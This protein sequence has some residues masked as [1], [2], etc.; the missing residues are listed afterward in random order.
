[1]ALH[2]SVTGGI[3]PSGKVFTCVNG[4]LIAVIISSL[5]SG[6]IDEDT[7]CIP[8]AAFYPQVHE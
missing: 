8:M 7:G 2:L 5:I 1:M 4:Y 3:S 6:T